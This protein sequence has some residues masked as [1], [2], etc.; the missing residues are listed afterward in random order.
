MNL[1]EINQWNGWAIRDLVFYMTTTNHNLLLFTFVWH[2]FDFWLLW[3]SVWNN[4]F[5]FCFFSSFFSYRPYNPCVHFTFIL[6]SFFFLFVVFFFLHIHHR[7]PCALFIITFVFSLS[8]FLLSFLFCWIS[9]CFSFCSSFISNGSLLSHMNW[10]FF[11]L[12]SFGHQS[13]W[14]TY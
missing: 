13:S 11:F 3:L 8:V 4:L 14:T 7:T 6:Y 2:W 10:N 1:C 5:F 9:F 12:S